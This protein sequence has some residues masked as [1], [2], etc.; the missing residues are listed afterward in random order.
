MPVVLLA[1]MINAIPISL[2][3]PMLPFMGQAYGASA[4]EVSILFAL[5]PIVG[6]VGNPLW[7]RISDKFGRRTAMTCTLV[8]TGLSF[9]AFAMADSMATLYLTRG[10]QGLF[11]GS[12]S[13]AL[14]YIALNTPPAE[15]AKGMGRV[16]GSMAV[17]LAIGP[18]LGGLL[19]ASAGTGAA[20]DH[21]FPC[22]VAGALSMVAALVVVLL[23]KDA[24]SGA[25]AGGKPK[26]KADFAAIWRNPTVW[27]LVL[28]IFASGYKFNAEQFVFPFWGMARGWD[29]SSASFA[30]GI[31]S[32]G[33]LV[34]SFVVVGA[35]TRRIGD[36]RTM[37]FATVVDLAMMTLFIMLSDNVY[38]FAC[39][40]VMSFSS[41][42]W[43][44]VLA[45]VLS[46][47]APEGH[48]GTIQGLST[49]TQL[50]GRIAGTLISGALAEQFGYVAVYI[51]VWVLLL[52]IVWQAWCFV[53]E[54][55][56]KTAPS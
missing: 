10:L 38:A 45:S 17:G 22:L 39:L 43:G 8:G 5:M 19:T 33:L 21:T 7:G 9:V 50:I 27:L 36:E 46:K 42:V 30:T 52:F 16:L 29:A 23:M 20:F 31:L 35:L 48:Q 51:C 37:L 25:A 13:I 26:P 28:M 12:N 15:R 49:S 3:M 40:M 44:T 32:C 2:V 4:F 53:R 34:T 14:A 11:H 47:H 6:I 41:P 54:S 18:T 1:V 24:S 56:A 55:R